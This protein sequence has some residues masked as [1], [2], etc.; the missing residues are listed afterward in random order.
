VHAEGVGY[1]HNLTKTT[2]AKTASA[3]AA[4]SM[5]VPVLAY[6]TA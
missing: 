4:F 1:H 5:K 3:K 2:V 6:A